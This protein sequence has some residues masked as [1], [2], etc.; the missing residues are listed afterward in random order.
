MVL[1]GYEDRAR[2][3]FAESLDIRR[4]LLARL[5]ELEHAIDVGANPVAGNEL[6]HGLEI[7]SGPDVDTGRQI[8]DRSPDV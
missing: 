7:G 1:P 6:V 2:A 3:A 8:R 5:L 4:R